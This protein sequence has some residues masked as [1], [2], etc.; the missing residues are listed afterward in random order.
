MSIETT[1]GLG[2]GQP[3]AY[4]R[5]EIIE[6][7][8]TRFPGWKDVTAERLGVGPVAARPLREER[9]AAARADG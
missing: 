6:P 2:T 5:A 9:Q 1:H 3:Y 4:R 7:D 8:W